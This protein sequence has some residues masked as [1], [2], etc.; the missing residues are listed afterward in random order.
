MSEA[1]VIQIFSHCPKMTF[2]MHSQSIQKPGKGNY[3]LIYYEINY[4][5]HANYEAKLSLVC[6]LDWHQLDYFALK[7]S[8]EISVIYLPYLVPN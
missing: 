5:Y 8:T 2:G 4:F 6:Q 1:S 7:D 3:G